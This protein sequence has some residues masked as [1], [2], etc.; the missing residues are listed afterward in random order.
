MLTPI[1]EQNE[2]ARQIGISNLYFKREDL[3]PYG[4]HK[5]RSI[6]V[7]IDKKIKRGATKFAI[8]SSGNAALA[9]VRYVQE[10]NI[11]GANLSLSVFV[12]KNINLEK[13]NKLLAE[14]HDERIT[15]A[16]EMRPLQALFRSTGES[17]R[18][19]TDPLALI[20]YESLA[21]EIVDVSGVSDIFIGASSGTAA[22]ALAEYFIKNKKDI[23]VHIVQPAGNSPLAREFDTEKYDNEISLADAIVDKTVFRKEALVEAIKK[24]H[25]SGWIISNIDLINAQKIVSEK[26]NI[27]A[28]ANGILG[29]AGL[30]KAIKRGYKFH[31]AVVCIITGQ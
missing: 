2:L 17:L 29:F 13:K 18:Q 3:H 27:K 14:I 5:G 20:G 22:E 25:G 9:A 1:S 16:E 26:V 15:L 30:L 10:K 6:P 8:S 21:S 12:G 28:T 11:G 7:M 24:T 23:S 31:G 19:S 4:S